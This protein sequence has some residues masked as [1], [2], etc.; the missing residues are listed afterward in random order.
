MNKLFGTIVLFA[1]LVA[2]SPCSHAKG[3][4]GVP[5]AAYTIAPV[6]PTVPYYI[7][8]TPA[9]P[10]TL[11]VGQS[12]LLSAEVY[13]QYGNLIANSSVN[14]SNF[15]VQYNA[16]MGTL[17]AHGN[18]TAIAPG[19]D[20][21]YVAYG[22]GSITAAGSKQVDAVILALNLSSINIV[23]IGASNLSIESP[24]PSLAVGQSMQLVAKAYGS[25]QNL[26][27]SSD[28]S[29]GNF[30]W[31]VDNN[32]ASIT[33]NGILSA[34]SNGSVNVTVTYAQAYNNIFGQGFS[35]LSEGTAIAIN[36]AA[37]SPS[38]SGSQG[39]SGSS[40]GG[41]AFATAISIDANCAGQPGS[42]TVTY[43]TND[44]L[45]ASVVIMHVDADGNYNTVFSGVAPN[46]AEIPFTPQEFGDYIAIVTLD[47]EQRNTNFHVSNCP[48]VPDT[49]G[50][51]PAPEPTVQAGTSLV[52]SKSVA[53]QNGFS[54]TFEVY[55]TVTSSGTTFHTTKV[56]IRFENNGS[57]A[58]ENFNVTD[59]VPFVVADA[60]EVTFESVP[61][62]E[63][64]NG[65]LRATWHVASL[66]AGKALSY[67]YSIGKQL[68]T[69]SQFGS[70]GAPAIAVPSNGA[71]GGLLGDMGNYISAAMVSL[72]GAPA[73]LYA[74][75][76]AAVIAIVG[77][78]A[79]MLVS[80]N[81]PAQPGQ[82]AAPQ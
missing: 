46:N 17:G 65:A 5:I 70:F 64:S 36:E 12:A 40:N 62:K 30:A 23:Q 39:N 14:A 73:L 55:K 77:A 48:S 19:S 9:G 69:E 21:I 38:N 31:S 33:S 20:N 80:S 22:N 71:N 11:I 79:Y 60:D 35:S 26:I 51:S 34:V 53:Y 81:K 54:R 50:N 72:T 45:D 2:F 67:T 7:N 10:L 63:A 41:S 13:D 59:R 42:L 47:T 24:A 68:E 52:L 78:G 74:A 57:A 25:G 6:Y 3:A 75:G 44:S 37:S 8:I 61:S 27:A 66:A 4:A 1:M 49:P 16:S 15:S 28:T 56:T 29:P 58:L 43:L 76:A 82:P 18:Y 32:N